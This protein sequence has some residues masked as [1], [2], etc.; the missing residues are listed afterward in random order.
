VHPS[1]KVILTMS[2]ISLLGGCRSS[3]APLTTA[4]NVDLARFMGDWYVIANI[5]TSLERGAHNAVESYQL[6]A[7]GTIP[8]TFTFRDG[9]FDG[10]VK[11][12]CPRGFV[13]D[14]PSKAVW[15]MQFIW[16]IKADYRIVYVSPDYQRTIVG[17]QKRDNVW[18]MARSPQLDAAQLQE[19]R[20]LVA[21]EGYDMTNY[22][23]VP[24]QW[25]ESASAPPRGAAEDCR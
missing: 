3:Q 17:R 6:A 11:R 16:P 21:R 23:L 1:L 24:Q 18:V 12:Y 4:A 25:P 14:D 7:D 10:E 8:T 19:L 13:R 5:P 2:L 20:D 22:Q 9:A 15:G